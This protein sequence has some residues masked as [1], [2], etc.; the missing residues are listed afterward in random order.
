M[1]QM[2]TA[3]ICL[4]SLVAHYGASKHICLRHSRQLPTLCRHT[5]GAKIPQLRRCGKGVAHLG[6]QQAGTPAGQPGWARK[7]PATP[8]AQAAGEL[9][10]RTSQ[11]AK[12]FCDRH[13]RPPL[14]AGSVTAESSSPLRSL[15]P[16]GKAV[17]TGDFKVS[18]IHTIHYQVY[19][20]PQGQPVLVVHGGPGA[21]CYANHAYV[22]FL[23]M[24]VP[25]GLLGLNY[26]AV[27]QLAEMFN[28]NIVCCIDTAMLSG[29]YKDW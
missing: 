7:K 20:N 9:F 18:D 10:S 26:F 23:C 27:L 2:P 19:G 22:H 5:V 11:Q 28:M 8:T 25:R 14:Y 3:S 29:R 12:H 1:L 6:L 24:H 17:E 4:S 16:A 13:S 15:H 21:G